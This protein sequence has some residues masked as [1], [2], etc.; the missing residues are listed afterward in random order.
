MMS[1]L[2]LFGRLLSATC[3]ATI[4]LSPVSVWAQSAAAPELKAAFLLNFVRFAEWPNLT[5][6]SP[7]VL[8]VAGDERVADAL[9]A[10]A[11]GQ[12]VGGRRLDVSKMSTAGSLVPRCHLLF[13]SASDVPLGMSLVGDARGLP[14][15][16]VSDRNGFC[17]SGGMIELFVDDARMRFAVN[18][19]TVERSGLRLSSRLLGLAR[20]VR[21]KHGQ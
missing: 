13:V 4:G 21:D 7:L 14:I 11:R 3:V 15:M 8:C 17:D 5:A 1:L 12:S 10:A 9:S 2:R 18:L 6:G 16:T 20:V 19:D